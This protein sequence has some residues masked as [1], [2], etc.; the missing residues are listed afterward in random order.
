M[1]Y[2]PLKIDA[3]TKI[4]GRIRNYEEEVGE[5]D[6]EGKREGEK[7]RDGATER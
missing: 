2:G 3:E 5:G 1:Q 6:I 7:E 4:Y